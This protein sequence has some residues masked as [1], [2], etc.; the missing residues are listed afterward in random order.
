MLFIALG[1]SRE[2][3]SRS[4]FIRRNETDPVAH[5]G[6]RATNPVGSLGDGHDS[7]PEAYFFTNIF[8]GADRCRA[9]FIADPFT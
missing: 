6:D 4:N 7:A 1:S 8:L 9:R 2:E 3:S 5:G